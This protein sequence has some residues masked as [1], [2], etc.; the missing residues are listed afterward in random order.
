MSPFQQ[1][2]HSTCLVSP[3]KRCGHRGARVWAPPTYLGY[4]SH[5]FLHHLCLIRQGFL[6][7]LEEKRGFREVPIKAKASFAS[8]LLLTWN[9]KLGR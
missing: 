3:G 2:T 6:L 5:G 7:L 9:L 1:V 8:E 4:L